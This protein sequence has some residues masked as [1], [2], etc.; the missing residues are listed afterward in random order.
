MIRTLRAGS[1]GVKYD[2]ILAQVCEEQDLLQKIHCPVTGKMNG[3]GE[4]LMLAYS[5][6]KLQI[7]RSVSLLQ[8][9]RTS[10]DPG[11]TCIQADIR[12][13]REASPATKCPLVSRY[14]G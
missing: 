9:E 2:P 5:V 14:R 7:C 10:V 3:V 12:T 1:R 13:R 4:R 8:R 6:E 11:L